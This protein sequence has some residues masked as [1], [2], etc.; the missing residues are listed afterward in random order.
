MCTL[1]QR[2]LLNC[3]RY[4]NILTALSK[5]SFCDKKEVNQSSEKNVKTDKVD[6]VLGGIASKYQVFR[7]EDA[8]TILDINEERFKYQ[9][10]LEIQEEFDIYA[11][12]NLNRKSHMF[13][14]VYLNFK[15]FL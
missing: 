15:N 3:G 12:L 10:F 4:R 5:R 9:Q 14:T 6:D 7:N 11:G 8:S 1:L 2:N 13:V